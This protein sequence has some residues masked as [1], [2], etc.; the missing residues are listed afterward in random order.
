MRNKTTIWYTRCPVPTASGI[1]F[2]RKMFDAAFADTPYEVR[3]IKELGRDGANTHFNHTLD[4]SFRE[5]G[6]SPPMWAYANGSDTQML[7]ITFMDEILGIY[8]RAD[9]PAEAW[10]IWRASGWRCRYGQS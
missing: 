5:G 3:N 4:A 10:R 9:D 1:A 7:A 6:G 2:Q 8:V